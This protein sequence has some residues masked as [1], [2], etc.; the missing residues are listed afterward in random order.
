ML[1]RIRINNF[2]TFVNFEWS[3]PPTCAIVGEN[4]AGKSALIEVLWLLQDVVV[5]GKLFEETGFPSTCTAWLN[6]PEQT[7]E[8]DLDQGDH[9]FRYRLSYR[10]EN[11]RGS[12][13]EEL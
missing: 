12:V 3:P 13:H 11:G 9:S 2:R 5:S 8:I 6:D 10:Q 7:F 4:G 1:K